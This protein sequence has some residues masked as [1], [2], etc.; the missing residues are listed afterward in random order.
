VLQLQFAGREGKGREGKGQGTHRR[1][2]RVRNLGICQFNR[3]NIAGDR[4]K[5]LQGSSDCRGRITG[6]PTHSI[7]AVTCLNNAK[8]MYTTQYLFRSSGSTSSS[9]PPLL[10]N[11]P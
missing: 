4:S 5:L 11:H 10:D 8:P 1:T 2:T 3:Y 9:W 7:F 6:G